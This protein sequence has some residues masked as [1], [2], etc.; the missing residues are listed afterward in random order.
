MTH[1]ATNTAHPAATSS[2][3]NSAR[4]NDGWAAGAVCSTGR[5][6]IGSVREA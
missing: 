6:A 4:R 1:H 2:Q 3:T 5:G